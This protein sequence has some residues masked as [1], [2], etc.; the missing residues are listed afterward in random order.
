MLL[1]CFE[2]SPVWNLSSIGLFQ[3]PILGSIDAGDEM[4][5]DIL[6]APCPPLQ[7]LDLFFEY[8]SSDDEDVLN[9]IVVH[10]LMSGSL[11]VKC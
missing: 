5:N 10:G 9:S 6:C 7:N 4:K 8:V 3:A 2:T 1:Q 11:P